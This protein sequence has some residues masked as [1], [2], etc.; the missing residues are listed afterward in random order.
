MTLTSIIRSDKELR[1]EISA[2]FLRPKLDKS[3]QLLAEP[4]TKRYSLVG[5]AFDY[6]FRFYLINLNK[7]DNDSKKWIS[8]HA[9]ELLQSDK[10]TYST[11]RKIIKN[12]KTHKNKFSKSGILTDVLIRET[13][14]MSYIDPIFRSGCGVEYIGEEADKNDIEDIRQLFELI[15]ENLFRAKNICLL[16][17]TFGE[18]SRLVGGADADFLIDDKLIDIK[19]TKKFSLTLDDFCQLIG[20]LL[21]HRISGINESKKLEI[22]KLGI[23]YSRYGYLFLFNVQ[24]IIDEKSLQSF[25]KWFKNR[26]KERHY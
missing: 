3:K 11:G 21:L 22:N 16:N 25:T 24:D 5:T 7:V 1:S 8:E 14:R 18:A 19:T 12:V 10:E 9:I 4:R 26:I 17:P 15:D 2:N 20:Y 23:Y 13:L 6:I